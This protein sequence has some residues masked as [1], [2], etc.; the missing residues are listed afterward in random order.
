MQG[1]VDRNVT[2][3]RPNQR[4]TWSPSGFGRC[5]WW[6][7]SITRRCFMQNHLDVSNYVSAPCQIWAPHT[8]A[9]RCSSC[10]LTW[11]DSIWKT[12]RCHAGSWRQAWSHNGFFVKR[13]F[14]SEHLET[15][16]MV[17]QEC[18]V[19]RL[20]RYI[21]GFFCFCFF[22]QKYKYEA[23][24]YTPGYSLCTEPCFMET[25]AWIL[26]AL[27]ERKHS[28]SVHRSDSTWHRS[29]Q[30]IKNLYAV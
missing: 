25:Q 30:S 19:Q 16:D 14:V 15:H 3:L 27:L 2:L 5:F 4:L 1:D 10:L 26:W 8:H 28:I 17:Q 21:V 12:S 6:H 9:H 29:F 11:N 7:Q 23:L 24:F 22:S 18:G 13:G 20:P